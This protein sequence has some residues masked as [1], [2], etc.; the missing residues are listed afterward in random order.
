MIPTLLALAL[1]VVLVALHLYNKN[2]T[3]LPPGPRGLPL[4]GNI[5]QLDISRPWRTFARWKHEYGPMVYIN[6]AGQPIIIL[7]SKTATEDLL[8]KRS[9]KYSDRPRFVVAGEYL[10]GDMDFPI[11]RYGDRWRKMRRASESALGLK[12]VTNFHEKQADECVLLV[13]GILNQPREWKYH[14][15]RT[16]AS[17]MLSIT[18]SLPAIQSPDYP[19]LE[20]MNQFIDRVGSAMLPG[21]NWIDGLPFLDKWIPDSMAKWRVKA[22]EDFQSY[23]GMFEKLFGEIKDKFIKDMEQGSNFC[24]TL[25]ETEKKHRMSDL[26]CSW[27]AGILYAAG[28]ETSTTALHWFLFSMLI[29]PEVQR[30]AQDELDRVVGRARLPTLSDMT[31]LPYIQ[32]IVKEILRWKP[33]TPIG[34]PHAAVEDDYYDGHFI[35]KGTILIPNVLS[36][37]RDPEIYGPDAGQFHPERHLDEKG[38]L[39][40]PKSDGH[41]TYGFGYRICVG[42][43]L[44]NNFLF[45]AFANILWALRIEPAKDSVVPDP[46]SEVSVN[47]VF[48]RPPDFDFVATTRFEDVDVLIQQARDE[49]LRENI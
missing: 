47:G 49:V 11:I 1:A 37:N 24:V 4:L 29:F 22:R 25:V 30:R 41:F 8:D 20:F 19:A 38:E 44:A 10:T 43:H 34:V 35:P 12:T 45:M 46:Q 32:A 3:N 42:R 28:Q 40:D 33:P 48:M 36:L 17:F 13:H 7:N 39:E 9:A 6:V 23:S 14:T 21:T 27:L 31:H 15:H 26:E 18:Y 2:G 16:A 5:F